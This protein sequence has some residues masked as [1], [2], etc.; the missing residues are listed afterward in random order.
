MCPDCGH[1]HPIPKIALLIEARGVTLNSAE[2][3][4]HA[5]TE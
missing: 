3:N 2:G 5:Q 1:T 4:K